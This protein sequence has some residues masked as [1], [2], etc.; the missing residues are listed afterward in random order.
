MSESATAIL[1]SSVA[2]TPSRIGYATASNSNKI[3]NRL[4]N[5]QP[6]AEFLKYRDAVVY[7][8]RVGRKSDGAGFTTKWMQRGTELQG[9]AIAAFELRTGLMVGPEAFVTHPT[10]EWAGATPDGLIG[11][12]AVLE[13]KVPMPETHE[14]WMAGGV[15]PEMHRNQILMQLACT[16]RRIGY[17]ASYDPDRAESHSLFVRK[18]IPSAEEIAAMEADIVFFLA[19]VEAEFERRINI[20]AIEI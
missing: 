5:G 7:E 14:E 19:A 18:L 15:V 1:R 9:A 20:E 6:G 17:F 3:R 11:T 13:V 12:D 10:I 16:G 2:W 4:K 8:R